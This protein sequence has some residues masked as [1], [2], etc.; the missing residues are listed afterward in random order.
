MLVNRH[1]ALPMIDDA[2]QVLPLEDARRIGNGPAGASGL[3][4]LRVSADGPMEIRDLLAIEEPMETRLIYRS[5]R[6]RRRKTVAITMRT[7]GNDVELALGFLFGEGI[8][9][10]R[11]DFRVASHFGPV[12]DSGMRNIVQVELCDRVEVDLQGLKRNFYTTSSCG[13][14][15]KAS[16]EALNGPACPRP[17]EGNPR[18][19]ADLIH[20]LPKELRN[21]QALFESTGGLH[22]AALFDIHGRLQC[23]REDVGRHN[24]MDKLVGRLLLD[25]RLPAD[26]HLLVLSGR[27]SFE[28]MQKAARAGI[29]IVV[30]IGAPSTLAVQLAGQHGITLVG[31]ARGERFNIYSA[32]SRVEM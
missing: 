16:I 22:A 23:L 7:P 10:S 26:Q 12:S 25:A 2:S 14:C 4:V 31:F 11:N 18:V 24:A 1:P 27:S 3:S 30:A 21:A 6:Q 29:P 8:I 9:S 5:G 20:R 15:G 28:L 19:E 13:V 32:P 17:R